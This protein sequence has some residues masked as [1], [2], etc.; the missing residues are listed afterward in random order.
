MAIF[1]SL[2]P[3]VMRFTLPGEK[4]IILIH[5][6][7]IDLPEKNDYIRS[8]IEQGYLQQVEAKPKETN[9]STKKTVT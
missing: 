5:G 6:Q 4:E 1:K 8:L 9:R 2:N 3:Q 7:E